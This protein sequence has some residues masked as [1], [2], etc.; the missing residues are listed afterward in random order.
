[1]KEEGISWNKA[2]DDVRAERLMRKHGDQVLLVLIH[3]WPK[4]KQFKNIPNPKID[5]NKV[6]ASVEYLVRCVNYIVA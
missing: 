2:M 5:Q 6:I 1:M 3:K 4:M